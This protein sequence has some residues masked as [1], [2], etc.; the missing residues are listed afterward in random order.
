MDG[1][2]VRSGLPRHLIEELHGGTYKE[3]CS[4]CGMF[5]HHAEPVSPGWG[6]LHET[7]NNCM[8][9][10]GKLQ[11][12]IVHFSGEPFSTYLCGIRALTTADIFRHVP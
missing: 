11:D 2:H 10:D 7:G 3:W 9:C 6:R 12:T 5:Y 8:W 4:K 1:L